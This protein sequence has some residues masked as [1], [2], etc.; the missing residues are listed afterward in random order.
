MQFG[1][2]WVS[3]HLQDAL[4]HMLTEPVFV[5]VVETARATYRGRRTCPITLLREHGA[6]VLGHDALCIAVRVRSEQQALLVLASHGI[7]AEPGAAVRVASQPL[8]FIRLGIGHQSTTR[9]RSLARSPW[10]RELS[11]G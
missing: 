9:P 10:S 7:A 11:K 6:E 4:A 1:A 8:P 5:E 3:R 2:G